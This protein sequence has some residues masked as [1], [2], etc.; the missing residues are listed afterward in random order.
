[1]AQQTAAFRRNQW[2]ASGSRKVHT[3]EHVANDLWLTVSKDSA[4]NDLRILQLAV[5]SYD[6]IP[7]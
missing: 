7:C 3:V 6:R 4:G 2:V 5:T 1:M